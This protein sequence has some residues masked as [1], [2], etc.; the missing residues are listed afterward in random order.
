MGV[1]EVDVGLAGLDRPERPDATACASFEF[2]N[3]K[4]KRWINKSAKG[5]ALI[6]KSGP[7]PKHKYVFN[8]A[9]T[10]GR[11]SP[12]HLWELREEHHA[13][14]AE[15]LSHTFGNTTDDEFY[16]IDYHVLQA[17]DDTAANKLQAYTHDLMAVSA[18]S[19]L[20]ALSETNVAAAFSQLIRVSM[21]IATC[22]RCKIDVASLIG[23]DDL[24]KSALFYTKE[25]M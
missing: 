1:D 7:Y 18:G 12:P 19:M 25:R 4:M 23:D 15:S 11:S 22:S 8:V 24:E 14:I 21:G 6:D 20:A 13:T 10:S 2:W 3:Q 16:G 9:D 17:V 5:I